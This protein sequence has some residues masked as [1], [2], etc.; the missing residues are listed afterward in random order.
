MCLQQGFDG[1]LEKPIQ[2]KALEKGVLQFLPGEIVEHVAGRYVEEDKVFLQR[3]VQKKRKK[4]IVTTESACDIPKELLEK[5]DIQMMYLYIKTEKG[6]FADT[7]EIDTESLPEYLAPDKVTVFVENGS[8][9]EYEEFFGQML[10]QAEQVIHIALS[11]HVS[12]GYRNAVAAAKCFDHVKV[13]DAEQVSCG[14]GM[15]VLHA[16]KMAA[17]GS[18]ATQICT[19]IERVKTHIQTG[20]IFYG[21]NY[22]HKRGRIGKYAANLCNAFKLSPFMTVGQKSMVLAGLLYGSRENVWKKGIRKHLKK[23]KKVCTE[24]VYIA[25]VGLSVS[26]QELIKDEIQRTIPVKRI[27]MQQAS[28]VNACNIGMKTIGISYYSM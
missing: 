24:L 4:V 11:S 5:Y 15:L 26:E 18:G 12:G 25:H 3:M 8:I 13:I 22:L 2:G 23:R 10:T 17:G 1:Y 19:D 14:L 20:Y 27:I 28:F 9:E 16:A 6:R 7:K 21:T